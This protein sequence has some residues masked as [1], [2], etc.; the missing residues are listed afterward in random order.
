M[1]AQV[2]IIEMVNADPAIVI[3]DPEKLEQYLQALKTEA[4][5]SVIDISTDHGR[6]AV[7]SAAH[8][9]T[10]QKTAIDAAGKEANETARAEINK[11]DAVRRRVREE[12][13]TIRDQ[14]RRPLSQWEEQEAARVEWCKNIIL[15]LSEAA[16]VLET[17][18]AQSVAERLRHVELI[19]VNQGELQELFEKAKQAKETAIS[20]LNASI[21]RLQ[22]EEKDRAELA[23]LRAQQAEQQRRE[24]E[25]EAQE[26]AL[27]AEQDRELREAEAAERA[28]EQARV[29]AEQKAK[30]EI[31]VKEADH[32]AE[33]ERIRQEQIKAEQDR[34][35]QARREQAER[36]KAEAE[37]LRRQANQK[38]RKTVMAKASKALQSE[39]GLDAEK[40]FEVVTAISVGRIA[41]IQIQF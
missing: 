16:V 28:A 3:N 4:E 8:K 32:Q 25:R 14:I 6:K 13:D 7:A 24:Q 11:V 21:A 39:C 2:N 18:D 17:D 34:A 30:A 15:D 1:D 37:E 19:A 26:V 31:A 35:E 38:H 40:A 5:S 10:R 20:V 29:D 12:L 22:Q 23:E 27:K 36:D 33:L 9:V 41:N